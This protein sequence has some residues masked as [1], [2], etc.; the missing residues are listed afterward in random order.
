MSGKTL[1]AVSFSNYTRGCFVRERKTMD[2]TI[3]L[4]NNSSKNLNMNVFFYGRVVVPTCRKELK[5]VV[6]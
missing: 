1:K 4:F 2:A 3:M 6:R 5:S